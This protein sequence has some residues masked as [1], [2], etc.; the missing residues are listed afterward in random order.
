MR[1]ILGT[2]A[3]GTAVTGK[4]EIPEV[5]HDTDEDD[6]VVSLGRNDGTTKSSSMWQTW[7]RNRNRNRR[8]IRVMH[9]FIIFIQ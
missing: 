8:L 2:T 9:N 3:D 6:Y 1:K 5:A 7:L 4:I